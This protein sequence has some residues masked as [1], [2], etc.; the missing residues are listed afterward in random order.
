MPLKYRGTLFGVFLTFL[1]V[2]PVYGV[3][4]FKVSNYNGGHQI[5]FEAEAYDAR[6]PDT[7]QHF[8]VV[9]NK[10]AFGGKAINRTGASGGRL[11]Y[12]FDISWAGGKGGTW[13]FWGRVI[14]PS[15]QSDYMI[16]VGD[17]DDKAD[18]KK[19]PDNPPF[20]GGDGAFLNADDRIFEENI[21]PPWA[22][23]R[24]SHAE[25]HT[26]VLQDG[27]NTMYIFHR[28]GNRTVYWDVFMWAD[29]PTYRP[30]DDDYK[31]AK[32]MKA[33]ELRWVEPVGKL[34]T[35]WAALKSKR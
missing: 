32:E 9:K 23:G 12:I 2:L 14:N 28:Q 24:S 26:K 29:D 7:D 10:D 4:V 25:G 31:N 11:T 35:T 3:E 8:A 30:T 19:L 13:Y 17:P 18:V 15:N 21:G 5:W 16:V 1:V 34:A 20:P 6:E 33:S 22:W 27:E